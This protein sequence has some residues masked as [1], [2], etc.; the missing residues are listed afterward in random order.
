MNGTDQTSFA[1]AADEG[2]DPG[3]L[4]HAID[5]HERHTKPRLAM[6]WDYYRNPMTFTTPGVRDGRGYRLGQERGLPL[7]LSNPAALGIDNDDRLRRREVVIEN[8][9]AWRV[10]TMIDFL[11]GKPIRLVSTAADAGL[12]REI[13]RALERVWESSGGLTLLQEAALYGHVFGHVDLRVRRADE[14]GER[15]TLPEHA[16]RI[17]VLD[18]R[19]TVV[20]HSAEAFDT[21]DAGPMGVAI[22]RATK[23]PG[24][25]EVWHTQVLTPTGVLTFKDAGDGARLVASARNGVRPGEVPVAHIQNAATGAGWAGLGEVE[26]LVSLQ[27]ELNTRLSDRAYRVTLQ[28]FKMYLVKGLGLGA[29]DRPVGPGLVWSTDNPDAHIEAFGGDSASPSESEHIEQIREAMDKVSAV[30]PLATGVVRARIGNLSSEN[31]LRLTLQGLLSRT[32]RKRIAYGRGIT[33]ACGLVLDALHEA[34]VLRT[35]PT[36]RTVRIEWPEAITGDSESAVRGA[37]E[38]LELGITREQV[39]TELG[40]AAGDP[41]VQ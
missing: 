16:V 35:K 2:I 20:L 4:A 24:Q 3:V 37:K 15:A 36:D 23:L 26:P 33:R 31:A 29:G 28:S 21:R 14:P 5:S 13:E 8:D 10:G 17:D 18:P 1:E 38:K 7:R 22:R 30:P 9:I 41:G 39:L 25:R 34:G 40:Y 11:F 27:D 19:Q 6:L 32:A 12:A